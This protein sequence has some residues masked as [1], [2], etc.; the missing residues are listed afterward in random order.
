MKP[1][2][3]TKQAPQIETST[4]DP[5]PLSAEAPPLAERADPKLSIV[6][7]AR[8]RNGKVARLPKMERDLVNQMLSDGVPYERIA[9]ALDELGLVVSARNISSWKQGGHQDWLQEQERITA[10][11]NRQDAIADYLRDEDAS[12]IPEVALQL[13]ATHL[14]EMLLRPGPNKKKLETDPD[15][16]RRLV[17][18]L[19]RLSKEIL[20]HQKYHDDAVEPGKPAWLR[21][22]DKRQDLV[23]VERT[24]E[25]Y[26]LDPS[27]LQK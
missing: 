1:Q 3:N 7:S 14:C 23:E 12:Q 5:K 24:R 18:S 22:E 15:E 19:C 20:A 4:L 8:S 10:T 2:T 21:Q 9:L 25:I 27:E 6:N 16:F 17:G 13:A 26:S 11:R